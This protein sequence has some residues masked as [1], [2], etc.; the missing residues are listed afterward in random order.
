MKRKS[1][2]LA[3]I[4]AA[5]A[6][7]VSP[8]VY[9]QN[10]AIGSTL[11]N[12][13]LIDTNNTE[14]AF[15]NLKGKKGTVIIFLSAQCPVVKGYNERINQIAADYESKGISFIGLYPNAT[16]SLEYVKTE[17]GK[18]GYKFPLLLDKGA[19]LADKLGAT[20]TPEV[21]FFDTKNALLYHG[22]IDNS[23]DGQNITSNFLRLAFDS[24]LA[25]KPIEKT[26]INAFGCSIKKGAKEAKN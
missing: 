14:R 26:R 2:L 18:A 8:D 23:R 5:I 9:G 4:F 13:T 6:F 21:Y 11:D 24:T 7:V 1:I 17:A 22:A 12:F 16:E 20:V 19:V 10:F 15:D 3:V 25:G